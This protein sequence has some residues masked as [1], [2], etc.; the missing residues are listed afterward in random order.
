MKR[1]LYTFIVFTSVM[2]NAHAAQTFLQTSMSCESGAPLE[3]ASALLKDLPNQIILEVDEK[4]LAFVYLEGM[5]RNTENFSLQS[6]GEPGPRSDNRQTYLALPRESHDSISTIFVQ[7]ASES[8]ND[9]ILRT[10]DADLS[11]CGGGFILSKFEP[12]K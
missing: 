3:T 9:L 8:E 7:T 6:I 4:K 10:L 11:A 1:L 12:T 5:G 2:S